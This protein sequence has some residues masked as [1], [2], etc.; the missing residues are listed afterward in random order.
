MLATASR[1]LARRSRIASTAARFKAACQ[2]QIAELQT[3]ASSALFFSSGGHSQAAALN[4]TIPHA[5]KGFV[6]S[7]PTA[8]SNGTVLAAE[9]TVLHDEDI[10]SN[11]E[12]FFYF[13]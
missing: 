12:V 9:A 8:A 6:T 7:A 11:E 5:P 3:S 2:S 13:L 10:H 4:G 1:A